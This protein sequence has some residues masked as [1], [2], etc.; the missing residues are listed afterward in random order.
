MTVTNHLWTPG[1]RASF[2]ALQMEKHIA[3]GATVP[4][5]AILT[6]T[7][8]APLMLAAKKRGRPPT[9]VR[10]THA[11]IAAPMF[12]AKTAVA[13]QRRRWPA[14]AKVSSFLCAFLSLIFGMILSDK[15]DRACWDVML[16]NTDSS[17]RFIGMIHRNDLSE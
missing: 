16:I 4:P 17:E 8:Q 6:K 2:S 10:P 15:R 11:V 5:R 12:P 14:S 7:G 13:D 3:N 9:K 1:E